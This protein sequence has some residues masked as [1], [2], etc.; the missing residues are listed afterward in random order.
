MQPFAL[1]QSRLRRIAGLE[2]KCFPL[3][4]ITESLD[5]ELFEAVH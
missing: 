4:Q 5:I 1:S 3:K 2:R